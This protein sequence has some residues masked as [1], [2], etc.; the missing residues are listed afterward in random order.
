[1]MLSVLPMEELTTAGVSPGLAA[2]LSR[3]CALKP[4]A[5]P[6]AA[7]AL[8]ELQRVLGGRGRQVTPQPAGDTADP[9]F[10]L[11]LPEG[12]QLTPAYSVRRW[13]GRGTFGVVYQ[14]YDNLADADLAVKIVLKDRESVVERLRHEYR[15]LRNLTPHPNVV[16]VYNADYLP[17]GQIPYLALPGSRPSCRLGTRSLRQSSTPNDLDAA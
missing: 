9:D 16:R 4:S 5:R 13:L 1:M 17:G 8:R 7:E 2:L 6:C 10:Y 3:M 12:Y 11:N 14:V 15:I